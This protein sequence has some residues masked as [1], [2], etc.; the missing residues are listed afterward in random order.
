MN[1]DELISKIKTIMKSPCEHVKNKK[2]NDVLELLMKNIDCAECRINKIV[3]TIETYAESLPL[4]TRCKNGI[5][6]SSQCYIGGW[7]K[8]K[9]K[10]FLLKGGE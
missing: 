4:C 3:L 7:D 8:C 6:E 10:K 5:P 1:R 9:S 2:D